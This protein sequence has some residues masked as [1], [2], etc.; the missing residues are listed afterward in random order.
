M[1]TFAITDM[2]Q[3]WTGDVMNPWA[4]SKELAQCTDSLHQCRTWLRKLDAQD[5]EAHGVR[6]AFLHI[7][8]I[9]IEQ[10]D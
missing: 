1:L 10:V 5:V 4:F 7:Q 8:I 9:G 3:W 6:R 2:H